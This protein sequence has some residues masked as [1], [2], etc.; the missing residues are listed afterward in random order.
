M[1]PTGMSPGE[2]PPFHTLGDYVFQRLCRDVFD[3]EPGIVTCDI[4]GSR[5]QRQHG[6]DL[7]ARRKI[8]EG[9]EVGQ[10]KCYRKFQPNKIREASDEFFKH[11]ERWGAQGVKRFVLFVACDLDR[12]Q[13]QNEISKQVQRFASHGL[14]YEAWSAGQIRGKLRPYPGIVSSYC[15]PGWAWVE[16]ICGTTAYDTG[17]AAGGQASVPIVT[18]AVL[19]TQIERLGERFSAETEERLEAMRAAWREGREEEAMVWLRRITDDA[20]VWS[21]LAPAVR[22]KLR[23]FQAN[24]ELA[25]TCDIARAKELAEE[26]RS[27]A[28]S[29]GDTRLQ[30]V[31]CYTESSAEQALGVLKDVSDTDSLNLRAAL[32]LEAAG[33]S[34]CRAV[35]DLETGD[36]E[37][38]AESLRILSLSYLADK[39]VTQAQ[40]LIRKALEIE[41]RWDSIRFAAGVIDYFSAIS[42]AALP[43]FLVPAPD[44]TDW[45]LVKRD[46]DS[47]ERLRRAEDE[48]ARLAETSSST[49][50]DTWA[51]EAWRLACLANHPDRQAQAVLHCQK[52]LAA[53]RPCHYAIGWVV[54]R[55][56]DVDLASSEKAIEAMVEQG[57]AGISH[58]VALAACF[59]A[60]R[61][62]KMAIKLLGKTR[63]V[64]AKSAADALWTFWRT[65][66]LVLN[67]Q[68]EAALNEID[69]S[70]MA[71]G[72]RTARTVALRAIHRQTKE[73]DSL[74]AHLEE[75]YEDTRDTSV[76]SR[77]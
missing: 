26:A 20:S 18:S 71:P 55:N 51:F 10:C 75:S 23:R 7:L 28:P 46:E 37:A 65:Q 17:S 32:A 9:I 19:L 68:P 1:M 62:P 8:N 47:L 58:I 29:E 33:S 72:S 70:G 61:T 25:T 69:A 63:D 31:I 52:L 11:W 30:A 41:P 5:G 21:V 38:N 4:Y 48:F 76:M 16:E 22:A 34:E 67:G 13:Q 40:L 49:R 53:D 24:L 39:D 66:S 50:N 15:K 6:I 74:L 54:A 56:Y 44:P 36:I 3:T 64:F 77:L 2:S 12:T 35:L 59:M 42:P 27:I 45:G 57:T 43:D 60:R 14:E 73:A